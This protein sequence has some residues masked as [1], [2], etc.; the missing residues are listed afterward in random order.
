[1]MNI[2][3]PTLYCSFNGNY[4]NDLAYHEL[5]QR[6]IFDFSFSRGSYFSNKFSSVLE[7]VVYNIDLSQKNIDNLFVICNSELSFA[8][9]FQTRI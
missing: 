9:T 6:S 4:K 3:I 7:W 5:C 8:K 2:T 1:M